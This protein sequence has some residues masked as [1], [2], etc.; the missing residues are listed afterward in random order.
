MKSAQMLVTKKTEITG[1]G[2]DGKN[3]IQDVGNT[4]SQGSEEVRE[5]GDERGKESKPIVHSPTWP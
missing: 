2:D 5:E 3:G 4:S 1:E